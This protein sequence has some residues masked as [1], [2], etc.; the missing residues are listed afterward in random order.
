MNLK[1]VTGVYV[2]LTY[3]K[4]NSCKLEYALSKLMKKASKEVYGKGKM[5]S[6][7]NTFLTKRDVSTNEAIK[8]VSLAL[9]S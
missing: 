7:G 1:F 5:I 8:R 4:S 3:L 2:M 9:R 6:I